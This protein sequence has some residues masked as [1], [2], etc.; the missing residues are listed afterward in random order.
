[1]FITMQEWKSGVFC[2]F[3]EQIHYLLDEGEMF[4]P[5]AKR[6]P[7]Q[8]KHLGSGESSSPMDIRIQVEKVQAA[9]GWHLQ[10]TVPHQSL[11]DADLH[12]C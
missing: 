11:P 10:R 6:K 3:Q 9:P 2:F 12:R 7:C 8:A 4:S 5:F 1:M